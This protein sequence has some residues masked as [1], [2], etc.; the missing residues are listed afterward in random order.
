VPPQDNRNAKNKPKK[1]TESA[2]AAP[3]FPPGIPIPATPAA[4]TEPPPDEED[5]E[6]M[7]TLDVGE[8]PLSDMDK[9]DLCAP[10]LPSQRTPHTS[11]STPQYSTTF[12]S[13]LGYPGE[14]PQ[15][16]LA[17]YNINGVKNRLREVLRAA[18]ENNL[19][20]L[21][22]QEVHF[23]QDGWDRSALGL[24]SLCRGFRW[25]VFL[26]PGSSTDIKGGTAVL[27]KDNSTKIKLADD[28][29]STF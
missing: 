22:L 1:R 3:A 16:L 18:N 6:A 14:G 11:A 20:A 2:P 23:Y 15:A 17:S 7:A 8:L 5:L 29:R 21:L 25:W 19:D 27:I 13:T 9:E 4:T 10:A 26:A 24:R 28:S 12:D